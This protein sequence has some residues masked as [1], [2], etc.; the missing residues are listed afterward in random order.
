MPFYDLRCVE[1]G[2]ESNIIASVKQKTEKR[3]LCPECGSIN[4]ET[5]YKGAPAYIKN[6]KEPKFECPNSKI[7]GAGCRQRG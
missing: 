5:V 7:C 3:I 6:I 4:L 1:C 2:K